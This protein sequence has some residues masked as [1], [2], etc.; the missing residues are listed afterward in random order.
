MRLR[1]RQRAG[2]RIG[3][4]VNRAL[5]L[6]RTIDHAPPNSIAWREASVE[7]RAIAKECQR[8]ALKTGD[9]TLIA[10]AEASFKLVAEL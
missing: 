3:E 7:L 2:R 4:L 9:P 10:E 1:Q 5:P 6:A 8:L